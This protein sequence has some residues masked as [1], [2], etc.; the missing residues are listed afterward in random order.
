LELFAIVAS[1]LLPF[2]LFFLQYLRRCVCMRV[3]VCVFVCVR[4]C[5]CVFVCVC[6]RPWVCACINSECV[7]CV[8]LSLS[9]PSFFIP[10]PFSF[11]SL[12]FLL[13][14]IHSANPNTIQTAMQMAIQ[15]V[16]YTTVQAEI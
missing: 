10:F 12:F 3:C 7:L 1:L 9:P 16:K 14:R 13:L 6:T 4:V 5:V 2:L 11:Y 15:T 8:S